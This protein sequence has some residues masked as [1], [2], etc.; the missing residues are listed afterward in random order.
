[1]TKLEYRLRHTFEKEIEKFNAISGN[2]QDLKSRKFETRTKQVAMLTIGQKWSSYK[3]LVTKIL[4][5]PVSLRREYAELEEVYDISSRLYELYF[6]SSRDISIK[7]GLDTAFLDISKI[8][9]DFQSSH[10]VCLRELEKIES[11]LLQNGTKS[12]YFDIV[13]PSLEKLHGAYLSFSNTFHSYKARL[14]NITDYFSF[15]KKLE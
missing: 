5:V 2:F 6:D 14:L 10:L 3:E 9:A 13:L 4:E 15:P 11:V 7:A 12:P 8:F 1:L